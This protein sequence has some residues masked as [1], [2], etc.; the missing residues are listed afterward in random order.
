MILSELI[1]APVVEGGTKVGRVADLRFRLDEVPGDDD[2]MPQARLYGILVG[3]RSPSSFLGYERVGV[4]KPWPI[5]Q[6]LAWRERSTF[7]VLWRD[8][9]ELSA[10][11]VLV[12]PGARRWP[13]Q[14]SGS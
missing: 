2:Q 1:G 12:R 11:G 14:L 10:D 4:N 3:Q 8:I 5:A 9:A 13:S 7:L 6:I